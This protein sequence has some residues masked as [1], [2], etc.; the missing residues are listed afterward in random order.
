MQ[1]IITSIAHIPVQRARIG[2]FSQE[3]FDPAQ[4]DPEYTRVLI[5]RVDKFLPELDISD[6]A[7]YIRVRTIVVRQYQ[8]INFIE[9]QRDEKVAALHEQSNVE[10]ALLNTQVKLIESEAR[11]EIFQ[12]HTRFLAQLQT[13][14]TP[15]QVDG[16]KDGMTYGVLQRTYTG[17][18]NLLPQLTEEEK[19]Y[20]LSSLI[21]ARELAMDKGSSDAKHHTFGQYKGRIN[22]YLSA[23]A[24]DLKAA[25]AQLRERQ[26]EGN[27]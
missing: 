18:L 10:P 9:E 8:G 11:E 24:Y 6:S 22:N 3:G 12:L 27:E 21:E 4:V 26:N 20:I 23:R 15:P 16:I 5:S 19:R 25:E 14:L 17:Y 2:N 7:Q 1:R 13:E